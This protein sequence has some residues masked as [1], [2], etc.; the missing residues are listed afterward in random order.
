MS[1]SRSLAWRR[2]QDV[3]HKGNGMGSAALFKAEKNWKM[4]YLRSDKV[5]RGKQLG[6]TY[7]I[8]SPQ[9]VLNEAWDAYETEAAFYLQS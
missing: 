7:P 4:L 2:Y 5:K 9:R 8:Q 3:L 6:F 1:N